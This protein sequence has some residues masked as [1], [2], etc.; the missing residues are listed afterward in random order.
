MI[1]MMMKMI[2]RSGGFASGLFIV[3][4]LKHCQKGRLYESFYA[5]LM[6]NKDTMNR[7]FMR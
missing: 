1:T 3:T 2:M 7:R 4:P 6:N 5:V